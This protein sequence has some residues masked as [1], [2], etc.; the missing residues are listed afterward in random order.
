MIDE[1]TRDNCERNNWLFARFTESRSRPVPV[2]D[3]HQTPIKGRPICVPQSEINNPLFETDAPGT[4]LK[5][6]LSLLGFKTC[7]R[8]SK[9]ARKMDRLGASGC[10][11]QSVK[12]LSEIRSNLKL[13]GRELSTLEVIAMRQLFFV[14]IRRA[15]G[16]SGPI[17]AAMIAA[18]RLVVWF[19]RA[20]KQSLTTAENRTV[21]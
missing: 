10:R 19:N 11:Q 12:L 4:H 6:I 15:E 16:K 3:W 18:A 7:G 8:C 5:Q 1:V 13:N 21:R 20:V 17:D 9:T 14:A 2:G